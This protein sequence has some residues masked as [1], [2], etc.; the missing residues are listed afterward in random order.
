MNVKDTIRAVTATHED[1]KAKGLKQGHG[2][3]GELPCPV[4]KVGTIGYSVAS[5]NGH[6]WGRCST[7]D[8]VAWME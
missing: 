7:K 4:C 2:G 1:A 5:V 6:I 3:R 8:C